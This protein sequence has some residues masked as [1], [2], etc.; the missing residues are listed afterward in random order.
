MLRAILSINGGNLLFKFL[1]ETITGLTIFAII[2]GAAVLLNLVVQY[3][4]EHQIDSIVIL[5]LRFAE[6]ALFLV[7]L[8]LFC[9]FLYVTACRAWNDLV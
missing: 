5:G 6:Y 9:R 8:G 3:L 4:E 7:D 2:A 1:I